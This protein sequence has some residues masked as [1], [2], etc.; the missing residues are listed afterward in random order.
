MLKEKLMKW[1]GIQKRKD[2]SQ[3]TEEERQIEWQKTLYQAR[4]FVTCNN[5]IIQYSARYYRTHT[6]EEVEAR[7]QSDIES[8]YKLIEE[9]EKKNDEETS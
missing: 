2:L 1:L 7:F 5:P 8:L 9:L 4:G 6:P 3:M